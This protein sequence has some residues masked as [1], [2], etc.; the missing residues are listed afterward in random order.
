MSF[1]RLTK[2]Q[3]AYA[4]QPAPPQTAQSTVEGT[5]VELHERTKQMDVVMDFAV[6]TNIGP[7]VHRG[8][9][10]CLMQFHNRSVISKQLSAVA[11][12][13]HYLCQPPV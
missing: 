5:R 8:F 4:A 12:A 1:G 6:L 13:V 9:Y 2:T 11:A 10:H 3:H 7:G